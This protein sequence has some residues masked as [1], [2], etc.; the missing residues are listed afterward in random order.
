MIHRALLNV[1]GVVLAA[2]L[3]MIGCVDAE[4]DAGYVLEGGSCVPAPSDGGASDGGPSD[5]GADL[6]DATSAIDSGP[7]GAT[8]DP[9]AGMV[10]FGAPCTDATTHAECGCPAHHCAV[11]PGMS[12]GVCTATGCVENPSVCPAGYRCLDLS[13]FD[14]T[15]PSVC[16]LE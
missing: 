5:A 8:C 16:V 14:P 9:D 10:A 3:P 15:L 2:A 4:C 1:F 7:P 13:V 11:Q 12:A 6:G